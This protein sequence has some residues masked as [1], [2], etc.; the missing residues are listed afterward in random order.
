MR[1]TN[2]MPL[3]RPARPKW[4]RRIMVIAAT[5]PPFFAVVFTRDGLFSS[6][7]RQLIGGKFRRVFL[8]FFPALS[9][10]LQKHYGISGGCRSCG[11]SCKLLFQC[12]HW[13]SRSNL[14]SVY[15]DR[16]N[17][18]RLFPITPADI[19]DRNLVRGVQGGCGF[20]FRTPVSETNRPS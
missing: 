3:A 18:C 9:R 20:R 4:L 16:P 19:S 5:F 12:P 15:E 17:I 7:G 1:D 8:S 11:A 14:C 2:P 10:R 6:A 13:D